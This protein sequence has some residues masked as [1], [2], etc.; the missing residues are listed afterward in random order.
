MKKKVCIIGVVVCSLLLAMTLLWKVL[1]S[2]S[3]VDEILRTEKNGIVFETLEYRERNDLDVTSVG[4]NE[5]YYTLRITT[6]IKI[7]NNNDDDFSMMF[8]DFQLILKDSCEFEFY[9]AENVSTKENYSSAEDVANIPAK[10]SATFQIIFRMTDGVDISGSI[11]YSEW[12]IDEYVK[13]QKA[14][15]KN[16]CVFKLFYKNDK[17]AQARVSMVYYNGET[18]HNYSK[19]YIKLK[20]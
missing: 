1:D 5:Y 16:S 15:F 18:M 6:K 12:K 13:T 2:Y 4:R 9:S 14:E 7:T 10:T 17:I 11:E 8:G 3:S 20:D 19:G